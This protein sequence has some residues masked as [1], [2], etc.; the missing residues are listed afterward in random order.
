MKL[1]PRETVTAVRPIKRKQMLEN[2]GKNM[3]N[4]VLDLVQL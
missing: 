3:V 2:G 1:C 4:N